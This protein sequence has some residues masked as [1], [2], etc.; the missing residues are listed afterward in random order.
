MK[1]LPVLAALSLLLLLSVGGWY[2]YAQVLREEAMQ[3]S[4]REL[5]VDI[6][7]ALTTANNP[8]LIL[9]RAHASW[10]ESGRADFLAAYQREQPA[11]GQLTAVRDINEDIKLTSVWRLRNQSTAWFALL[12]DFESGPGGISAKLIWDNGRW[13]FQEYFLYRFFEPS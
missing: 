8:Q 1:T 9:D 5:I 11:L 3:Q 6:S 7:Q 4:S 10:S 2:L 13:Q 12:A